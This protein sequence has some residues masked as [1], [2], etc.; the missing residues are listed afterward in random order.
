MKSILFTLLL[1]LNISL[2]FSQ[3]DCSQYDGS[4]KYRASL[5][6]DEVPIDFDKDD[7]LSHITSLD[8]I[9]ADDLNTLTS[10][11]TNVYKIF[12]SSSSKLVT[13]DAISEIFSILSVL[14][15]SI[16]FH[17]CVE[18]DCST[19]EGVFQYLP[20]LF[21]ETV[22]NDFNKDDFIDFILEMDTVPSED[23]NTLTDNIISVE[24][25]FPSAQ[26]STLKRVVTINSTGDI[27]PIL[28]M[29]ENS[30]E[31]MECGSDE[32]VLRMNDRDNNIDILVYP[33]PITENS[34]IRLGDDFITLRYEIINSL[35]QIVHQG[36]HRGGNIIEIGKIQI[37]HG[38]YFIKIQDKTTKEIIVI[39][40]FK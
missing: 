24:K 18:N 3:T 1:V 19:N 27:Y 34:V 30:I 7:F 25:T 2:S 36:N 17:F 21:I 38:V 39:R 12:S 20:L 22:P 14:E 28:D 4:F 8:D 37:P 32:V 31:Y 29:L 6:I 5:I 26:S 40:I 10:E 33:N 11:I 23:V 9:S 13:I 15:N 35:G 16:D